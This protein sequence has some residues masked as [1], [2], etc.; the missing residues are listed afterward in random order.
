MQRGDKRLCTWVGLG[1][2][3]V[4]FSV[5]ESVVEG[6]LWLCLP[7]TWGLRKP[8]HFVVH[9]VAAP[10][11]SL[12]QGSLTQCRMHPGGSLS[13]HQITHLCLV[14]RNEIL[15]ILKTFLFVYLC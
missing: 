7:F 15:K 11:P 3:G 6:D 10:E 8:V 4:E 14:E 5:L 1:V 13:Q 9:V 12:Q 2:L